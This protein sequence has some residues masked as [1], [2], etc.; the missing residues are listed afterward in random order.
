MAITDQGG[1]AA[2]R[3]AELNEQLAAVAR[4]IAKLLT[5]P[6]YDE[7]ELAELDVEANRLREQIRQARPV[8]EPDRY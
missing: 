1:D 6:R 7:A 3:L 4:K 5:Q 8:V 2:E